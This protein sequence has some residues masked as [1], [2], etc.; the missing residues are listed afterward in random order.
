MTLS[1]EADAADGDSYWHESLNAAV[2]SNVAADSAAVSTLGQALTK[3]RGNVAQSQAEERRQL[4]RAAE[5]ADRKAEAALVAE[6]EAEWEHRLAS[7]RAGFEKMLAKRKQAGSVTALELVALKSKFGKLTKAERKALLEAREAKL[8]RLRKTRAAAREARMRQLNANQRQARSAEEAGAARAME[9]AR[10][11]DAKER[12]KAVL[13]V[14]AI[15]F[16]CL[17]SS[18]S[19]SNLDGIVFIFC[20]PKGLASD[21]P[22]EHCDDAVRLVLQPRHN[23]EIASMMAT[24]LKEMCS[25]KGAA[26]ARVSTLFYLPLHSVRILLTI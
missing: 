10:S 18:F 20:V 6:S 7:R 9:E 25:A 3:A 11:A 16:R 12:E 19:F 1:A 13:K 23:Q 22:S 21:I 4:E 8:G 2:A 15:C 26:H 5:S 14:C 24:H 17:S